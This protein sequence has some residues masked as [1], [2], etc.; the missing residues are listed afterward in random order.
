[1][2]QKTKLNIKYKTSNITKAIKELQKNIDEISTDIKPDEIVRQ[3]LQAGCRG[4][5]YTYNEP[6]IFIEYAADTARLAKKKGLANI[7]VSNGFE[8]EETFSYIRPYLDAINIDLKSFR[9]DFY[10]KVCHAKIAPVLENIKRYFGAGIETE[11]TTLI[12][13]GHNDTDKE[14]TDVAEFLA[15]ISPDIPWHISAFKPEYKMPDVPETPAETLMNA[16]RIGKKA[17]LHYIYVGNILDPGHSSTYCPR[18][19]ELLVERIYYD[20]RVRNIDINNG[21]CKKCGN[22]IY[23]VWN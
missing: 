15:G 20:T 4:I 19:N 21:K 2:S 12:I 8:S 11:V 6:A 7:F 14:L 3:A 1:M 18:C 23:G 17:G 10:R 16:Y 22:Q 5:A 9:D 13:P